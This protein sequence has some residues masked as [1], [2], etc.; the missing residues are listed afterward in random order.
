MESN[1]R[2]VESRLIEVLWGR[3]ISDY[4]KLGYNDG[5]G[6]SKISIITFLGGKIQE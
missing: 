1:G 2:T 4:R 3:G 6:N 5:I